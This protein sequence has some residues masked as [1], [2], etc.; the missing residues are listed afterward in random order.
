MADGVFSFCAD[1]RKARAQPN[2]CDAGAVQG[3]KKG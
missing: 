2:G 1:P 3:F